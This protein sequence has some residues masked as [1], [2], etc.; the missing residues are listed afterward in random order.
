MDWKIF[1]IEL[2]EAIA[3]TRFMICIFIGVAIANWYNSDFSL[4]SYAVPLFW[5]GLGW[6]VRSVTEL[7]HGSEDKEPE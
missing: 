3:F 6:I 1:L 2:V 5:T 4:M 7:A